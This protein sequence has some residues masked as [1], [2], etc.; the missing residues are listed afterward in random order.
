MAKEKDR[1]SLTVSL[2]SKS[3]RDSINRIV[4]DW[5]KEGL[6]VSVEICNCILLANKINK[7]PTLLSVISTYELTEKMLKLS[8]QDINKEQVEQIV[9]KMINLNINPYEIINNNSKKISGQSVQQ[10]DSHD[11]LTQKTENSVSEPMNSSNIEEPKE[12]TGFKETIEADE[13]VPK[14]PM[15]F[16]LNN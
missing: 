11:E 12:E 14:I 4:A 5:E 8:N 9:S 7:S 10:A 15:D 16:L 13:D 6:N 1:K 3:N 2:S